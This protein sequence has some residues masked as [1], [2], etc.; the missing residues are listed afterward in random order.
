LFI[1]IYIFRN[2]FLNDPQTGDA[3]WPDWVLPEEEARPFVKRA[4]ELGINFF[5]TAN[6]YA[7][8]TPGL[9]S[10]SLSLPPQ[11]VHYNRLPQ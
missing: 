11:L 7:A 3:K 4:L 9:F 1:Y 5:D 2:I 8:G 10:P 6:A